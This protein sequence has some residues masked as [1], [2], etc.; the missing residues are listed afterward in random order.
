MKT[1]ALIF[2]FNNEQTDYVSMAAWSADNIRRHLGIPVAVVTNDTDNDLVRS[3]F[4]CIIAASAESGGTRHFE[5]YNQTVTWHNAG[6]TNAY[7]LSPW[8]QTLVLD[9]DYVVA[10]DR[11]KSLFAVDCDFL[12]HK[13]AY[14]VSSGYPLDN[15]NSFGNYQF[16]MWWA[17]V[18]L[19]RRSVA[20]EYIFDSMEM[21]KQNWQH[22]RDLYGIN[23]KTYRNDF[24]LSIAL[25]IISGHTLRVDSI[26][27]N[28]ASVL[29]EHTV[30]KLEKDYY[31]ID[32]TTAAGHRQY[33]G[34]A[35]TD[36]HVMGKHSLE[37]IVGSR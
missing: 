25:G 14:D 26:P 18:M 37:K 20:A 1:G 4:D 24:A 11:L 36:M 35:G 31:Q 2:A 15:L 32:W 21:I 23:N 34:F 5:D 12:C 17:T 33:L 8:E 10:S 22:Y 28:L 13:N 29:P 3:K 27:W 30:I 16:P 6:R 19:F 9:A 7:Q